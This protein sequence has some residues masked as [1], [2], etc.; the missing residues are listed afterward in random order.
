MAQI[1]PFKGV[2]YNGE[3]LTTS[4][5]DV[6]APP[7]DVIPQPAQFMLYQNYPNP[8]NTSTKIRFQVSNFEFVNL[9]VYDVL[10][11]EVATLVN[12]EKAAGI[13]EVEFNAEGLP[14]GIYFYQI[15]AGNFVKNNK[16]VLLK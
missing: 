16:M 5:A 6:M 14:S 3:K 10:G 8:F 11:N 13:Y 15:K 9:K 2:L 1:K 12:E 7:Y 4:Y